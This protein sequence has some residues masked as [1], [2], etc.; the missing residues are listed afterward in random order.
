MINIQK[1]F[2]FFSFLVCILCQSKFLIIPNSQGPEA[3]NLLVS[4]TSRTLDVINRLFSQV[5][6]Q[7]QSLVAHIHF[8]ICILYPYF[9]SVDPRNPYNL[10]SPTHTHACKCTH[11]CTC[12]DTYMCTPRQMGDLGEVSLVSIVK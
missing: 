2:F 12:V 5:L 10:P 7:T 3:L 11:I 4:L 6:T 1:A 8:T 9:T